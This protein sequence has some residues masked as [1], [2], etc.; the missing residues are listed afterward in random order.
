MKE[1]E[2][3]ADKAKAKVIESRKSTDTLER[4]FLDV[5]SE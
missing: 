2:R 1:I 4:L 5:T 3:L